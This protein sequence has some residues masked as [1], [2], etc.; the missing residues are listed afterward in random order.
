[1][2]PGVSREEANEDT[3]LTNRNADT[4]QLDNSGLNEDDEHDLKQLQI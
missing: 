3:K 1:M 4:I 2:N